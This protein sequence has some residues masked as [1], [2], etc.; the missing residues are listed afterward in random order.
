M[1]VAAGVEYDGSGYHGWQRQRDVVSVQECVEQALSLVADHPVTVSCAGRTDTGVNAAQQV[2]HF[3]SPAKRSMRAWVM[4][5]NVNLPPGI[6]LLW[7][8]PVG[9]EFHARFSALSR[10]YQYTILNRPT[11][12]ALG[13]SQLTWGCRPLD[14]VRMQAGAR[15]LIGE[16]DFSAYRALACQAKSPMRTLHRLDVTRD[17]DRIV[18]DLNANGFLH[19]MV[20][21]IAGVLMAVGRGEREPE[22]VGQVLA[23]RDRTLGGVTAHPNGLCFM[24]VE[25]PPQFSLPTSPRNTVTDRA[26]SNAE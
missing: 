4:G 17:G 16:H 19:H 8:K 7:A 26:L 6:C 18:L 21:N 22:W 24:G 25:Y 10:S 5:G 14:V 9:D 2:I 20:R 15:Y 12:A 23:G 1:R 13:Y 3:D 11:R